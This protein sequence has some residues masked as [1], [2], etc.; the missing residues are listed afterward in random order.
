MLNTINDAITRK[1]ANKGAIEQF[2]F[3]RGSQSPNEPTYTKTLAVSATPH[4][5]RH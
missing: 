4:K 3:S 5:E 2:I 1:I